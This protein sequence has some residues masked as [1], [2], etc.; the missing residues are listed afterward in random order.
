MLDMGRDEGGREGSLFSEVEDTPRSRFT[1][2]S[3]HLCPYL[4]GQSFLAIINIIT[5]DVTN[6]TTKWNVLK[7]SL[8]RLKNWGLGDLNNGIYP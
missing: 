7:N 6:F 1:E 8:R 5:N 2:V 3:P 4:G